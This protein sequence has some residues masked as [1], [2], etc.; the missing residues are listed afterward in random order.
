MSKNKI[1]S[2]SQPLTPTDIKP[3]KPP[4]T[5]K[6]TSKPRKE[7][8]VPHDKN[9]DLPQLI[10]R[11]LDRLP[12][13]VM[14]GTPDQIANITN[15]RFLELGLV[16]P[17]VSTIY[18]KLVEL[19]VE[20]E[21][22]EAAFILAVEESS[23]MTRLVGGTI[24]SELEFNSL[25]GPGPLM[26][27]RSFSSMDAIWNRFPEPEKAHD[28]IAVTPLC[29][30]EER[31]DDL[32]DEKLAPRTEYEKMIIALPD[33][34]IKDLKHH[35]CRAEGEI[36]CLIYRIAKLTGEKVPTIKKYDKLYKERYRI[37]KWMEY[38]KR[39]KRYW[40]PCVLREVLGDDGTRRIEWI[41]EEPIEC[42]PTPIPSTDC[43]KPTEPPP[44]PK[45]IQPQLTQKQTTEA[46]DNLFLVDELVKQY[47]C[48]VRPNEVDDL[49]SELNME[50]LSAVRS[51]ALNKHSIDKIM[52]MNAP[53]A[54]RRVIQSRSDNREISTET[55]KGDS[56]KTLSDTVASNS[57]SQ[58]STTAARE[59][60]AVCDT[61]D[62]L[63]A[64]GL[65]YKEKADILEISPTHAQRLH[66]SAVR[67]MK[68]PESTD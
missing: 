63:K 19:A 11:L 21:K 68:K 67:S 3:R 2:K 27:V 26:N 46:A 57:P 39:L 25:G 29:L 58:E 4:K 44:V 1:E 35:E 32:R 61:M 6:G 33:S 15:R 64:K 38:R 47:R 65:T 23:R 28:F 10:L 37:F 17:K 48:K 8:P 59:Q 20:Y 45:E 22:T 66:K 18:E 54:L 55:P 5:D 52:Y 51:P 7:E 24:A 36:E 43:T 31:I 34:E 9:R 49:K 41:V 53:H 13:P 56:G 30:P 42:E 50:L 60:L 12:D 40:P 16:E 14:F 62:I